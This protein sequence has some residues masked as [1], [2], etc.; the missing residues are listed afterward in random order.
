MFS[1]LFFLV[2]FFSCIFWANNLIILCC[3][4]WN[5]K[6]KKRIKVLCRKRKKIQTIVNVL[7]SQ[8]VS[9]IIFFLFVRLFLTFFWSILIHGCC[10]ATE[11]TRRCTK[12]LTQIRQNKTISRP[13][14][15]LAKKC[16][17]KQKRFFFLCKNCWPK[18]SL[19][20]PW[21]KFLW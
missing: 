13:E 4:D 7:W 2:I 10:L 14:H 5:E 18:P 20:A 15:T 21:A 19:F 6:K 11:K 1:F 12:D 16:W 9:C 3:S 8:I 17:N